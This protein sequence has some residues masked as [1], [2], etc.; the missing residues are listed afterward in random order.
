MM[1][2]RDKRDISPRLPFRDKPQPKRHG[3]EEEDGGTG[4]EEVVS[5]IDLPPNNLT[6][7][8][9]KGILKKHGGYGIVMPDVV[10]QQEWAR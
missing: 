3:V 10:T 8:P 5:F 6:K 9:E 4:A 2:K 1:I 7:L